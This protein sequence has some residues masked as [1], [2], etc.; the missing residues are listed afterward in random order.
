MD[1][2]DRGF[3]FLNDEERIE[4]LSERDENETDSDKD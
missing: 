2:S 1:E 4:S 3:Q